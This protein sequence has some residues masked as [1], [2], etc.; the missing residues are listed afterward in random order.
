MIQTTV[1]SGCYPKSDAA[2][3]VMDS[4][5]MKHQ[6]SC[7]SAHVQTRM[8]SS[9]TLSAVCCHHRCRTATPPLRPMMLLLLL[10]HG[11][12]AVRGCRDGMPA[13]QQ[14]PAANPN[15]IRPNVVCCTL[16]TTYETRQSQKIGSN[17][18]LCDND[19]T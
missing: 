1:A 18:S 10:L 3:P 14:V 8:E 5:I 17:S 11:A 4:D 9:H 7:R 2:K 12:A 13:A 19:V 6:S 16:R 15:V